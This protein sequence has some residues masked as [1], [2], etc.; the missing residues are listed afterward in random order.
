ML[1]DHFLAQCNH[2]PTRILNGSA[3]LL[4][5]ILT[6]TPEFISNIEVL[7]NHFDSDRLPVALDIKMHCGSPHQST[8][9][10]VYNFKKATFSV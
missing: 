1:T 4:D 7:P 3:N 8:P 9:R 6:R 10:Q 5:L 2:L